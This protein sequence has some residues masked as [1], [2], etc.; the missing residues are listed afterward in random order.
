[1]QLGVV[2]GTVVASRKD[3][4]LEGISLLL[5]QPIR[6]DGS[7]AGKTL[8]ATD[9]M[10]AGPGERVMWVKSKEAANPFAAADVPTDA[11]IVGIVDLVHVES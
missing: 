8:V 9:T 5:V 2:C 3:E 1:M 6:P 10:G 7:P 11:T 4:R